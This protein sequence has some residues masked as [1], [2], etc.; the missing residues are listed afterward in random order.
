M[1]LSRSCI[2]SIVRENGALIVTYK[3]ITPEFKFDTVL[4]S[5]FAVVP[6]QS[7]L[8]LEAKIFKNKTETPWLK[9]AEFGNKENISFPPQASA[10]GG[11]ET[12]IFKCKSYATSF[13]SRLTIK[14]KTTLNGISVAVAK[15]KGAFDAGCVSAAGQGAPFKLAV[16]QL[17][18]MEHGGKIKKRIC[19]P[20]CLTM[21][22]N[23]YGFN[24]KL[25]EVCDGV[26]DKNAGIYGN[27]IF[28]TF[29][30]GRFGLTAYAALF[31]TLEDARDLVCC[32]APLITS[33][34][35]KEGE[36]GNAP[37]SSTAGHL[38]LVKGFDEN[39]NVIVND[40]AASSDGGVE[41]IYDR[42][43]FAAAWLKNK[44]GLCYVIKK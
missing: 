41:R 14:G 40:P 32:G 36:L 2:D 7:S 11:V 9:I 13:A 43:Q 23:Y 25:S 28:N 39:G 31:D 22:L 34:S 19:S 6:Q 27:W 5:P 33:V 30:A 8:L 1:L 37:L 38:V 10:L 44:R 4:F 17:S 18:Q 3:Q 12:D 42:A 15:Y 35:F 26:Y 16:P 20:A 24:Q 21:L 29:Y